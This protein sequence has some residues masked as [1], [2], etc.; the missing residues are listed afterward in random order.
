MSWKI[1]PSHSRVGFS[2]KHM[3]IATVRGEFTRYSGT[4]E[5]DTED[6]TRSRISGEIEVASIDTRE[7]QRDDHLRSSD[8]FAAAE[9][10]AIRFESKRL[11]HVEGNDYRVVGDLTIRGVTKEVV[12]DAEYAGVHKD[13]WGG[14][15]TG[16]TV[17]GAINRKDFG[18]NFNAA[19]ETGGVLVGD[20]VKLELEVEAV[21]QEA[22]APVA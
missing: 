20:K 16:F 9:H 22:A 10:P 4:L 14:T 7:S 18:M 17:T 12:L 2:V 3:M 8:F 5:L 21:L 15:R 1:D 6:L 19:L 11:E 13:P